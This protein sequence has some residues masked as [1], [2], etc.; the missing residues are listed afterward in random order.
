VDAQGADVGLVNE[1]DGLAENNL[2][3]WRADPSE[4]DLDWRREDRPDNGRG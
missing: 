1:I 3:P 4:S 2:R